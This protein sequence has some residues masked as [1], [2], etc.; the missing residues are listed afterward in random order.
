MR[1]QILSQRV[2]FVRGWGTMF[3]SFCVRILVTRGDY[4]APDSLG[5]LF[6]L[7]SIHKLLPTSNFN[8]HNVTHPFAKKDLIDSIGPGMS[9]QAARNSFKLVVPHCLFVLMLVALLSGHHFFCLASLP[10]PTN[11]EP[12]GPGACTLGFFKFSS[13]QC[14]RMHT[15][16]SL[17]S[18]T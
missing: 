16:K 2:E 14:L 5:T 15:K 8:T 7:L 9:C 6:W 10:A 17:C 4:L 12:L 11:L 3:P 18:C 1:F 13:M